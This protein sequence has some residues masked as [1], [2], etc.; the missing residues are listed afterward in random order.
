MQPIANALCRPGSF[1]SFILFSLVTLTTMRLV[2][3]CRIQSCLLRQKRS[4]TR[5][6]VI[7]MSS[8]NWNSNT[9][10]YTTRVSINPPDWKI[11]HSSP[12]HLVG[13]CFTDTISTAL[14]NQKFDCFTN[15]QGISFNPVSIAR[16]LHNVVECKL[17]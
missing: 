6:E 5:K 14:L 8:S 16:C 2:Q 15:G 3:S 17:F 10:S 9:Q 12:I 11:D 13:S 4:L 7:F 1:F